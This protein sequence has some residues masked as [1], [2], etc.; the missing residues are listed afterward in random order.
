MAQDLNLSTDLHVIRVPRGTGTEK[1]PS[2]SSSRP[3]ETEDGSVRDNTASDDRSLAPAPSSPTEHADRSG[4]HDGQPSFCIACI[5]VNKCAKMLDIAL[6]LMLK[7]RTLMTEDH[8]DVIAGHVHG[9]AGVHHRACCCKHAAALLSLA[10]RSSGVWERSQANVWTASVSLS[11]LQRTKVSHQDLQ[12][13]WLEAFHDRQC[14]GTYQS[15]HTV[16]EA[17]RTLLLLTTLPPGSS[18][19]GSLGGRT[20]QFFMTWSARYTQSV[21]LQN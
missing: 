2:S 13:F 5:H 17:T 12:P 9:A 11:R 7:V 3:M 8:V 19:V 21:G 15:P 14:V 20:N 16:D 18:N 4:G 10:F 1:E 6:D